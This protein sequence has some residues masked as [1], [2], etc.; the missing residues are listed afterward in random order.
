MLDT[1][2]AHV[3]VDCLLCLFECLIIHDLHLAVLRCLVI[4]NGALSPRTKFFLPADD[5][6]LF[7]PRHFLLRCHLVVWFLRVVLLGACSLD[8]CGC[9]LLVCR[10]SVDVTCLCILDELFHFVPD[11]LHV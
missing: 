10:P 11:K 6:L 1:S 4:L 2:V 3:A 9:T 7:A 5:L 8:D